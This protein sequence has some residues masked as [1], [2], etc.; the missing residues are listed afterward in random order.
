MNQQNQPAQGLNGMPRDGKPKL[1]DQVRHRCRTQPMA[2]STEKQYG[3]WIRRFILFH[4]KRHPLEMGNPEVTAFL[5]HLAVEGHV[6]EEVSLP[7]A[8]RQVVLAIPKRLRL[9]TRFWA[10]SAPAP[11]RASRPKYNA[12]AVA[13]ACCLA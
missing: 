10:S 1:L 12:C 11:G 7:V 3:S 4:N 8:H 6:A 2:R 9:H 13:R 5:T